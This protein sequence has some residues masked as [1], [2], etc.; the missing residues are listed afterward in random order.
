MQIQEKETKK[1]STTVM[2]ENAIFLNAHL[3]NFFKKLYAV[4]QTARKYQLI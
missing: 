1:R 4:L 3:K 2:Q